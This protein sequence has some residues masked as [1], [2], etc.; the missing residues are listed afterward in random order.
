MKGLRTNSIF[1]SI[2]SKTFPIHRKSKNLH[3]NN[4]SLNIL[5]PKQKADN[6]NLRFELRGDQEYYFKIIP[7]IHYRVACYKERSLFSEKRNNVEL[8]TPT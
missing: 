5:A 2:N 1:S 4:I 6:P 8:R 7:A 3:S